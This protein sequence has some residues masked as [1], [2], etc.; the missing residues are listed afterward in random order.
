[1]IYFKTNEKDYKSE[2][3]FSSSK[4]TVSLTFMH[5]RERYIVFAFY[6]WIPTPKSYECEHVIDQL[7]TTFIF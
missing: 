4:A 5:A 6:K 1:M 3:L 7:N 2:R